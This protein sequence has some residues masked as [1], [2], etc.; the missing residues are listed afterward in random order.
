MPAGLFL[1]LRL[2]RGGVGGCEDDGVEARLGSGSRYLIARR[3]ILIPLFKSP[4]VRA[5]V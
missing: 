3:H 1:R 2:R 4:P 5:D